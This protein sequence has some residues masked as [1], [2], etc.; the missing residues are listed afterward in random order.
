MSI[1]HAC[2]LPWRRYFCTRLWKSQYMNLVLREEMVLLYQVNEKSL[3]E[4][5]SGRGQPCTELRRAEGESPNPI[6]QLTRPLIQTEMTC[7]QVCCLGIVFYLLTYRMPHNSTC[8]T[9]LHFYMSFVHEYIILWCNKEY[10]MCVTYGLF[11]FSKFSHF[12]QINC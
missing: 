6:F 5:H 11:L 9:N 12:L 2:W 8:Q 7:L 1:W 4:L 10:Y 3:Y